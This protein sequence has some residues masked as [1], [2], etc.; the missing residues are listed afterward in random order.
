MEDKVTKYEVFGF[1]AVLPTLKIKHF[2]FKLAG[3]P[4]SREG[5]SCLSENKKRK[6]ATLGSDQKLWG[7]F[8][9]GC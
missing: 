8:K 4:N 5:R 3:I 9:F 2:Y 6:H 1:L 7:F